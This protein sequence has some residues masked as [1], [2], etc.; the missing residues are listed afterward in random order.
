[1]TKGLL[2]LTGGLGG[3]LGCS[4]ELR[5]GNNRPWN[6][7][8][9]GNLGQGLLTATRLGD[10]LGTSEATGPRLPDAQTGKHVL[11]M[12]SLCSSREA[13]GMWADFHSSDRSGWI[14]RDSRPGAR[15]YQQ[16][17]S[18]SR[19]TQA[20]K[21]KLCF[22][23]S[24]LTCRTTHL[25]AFIGSGSAATGIQPAW[26]IPVHRS[27]GG[28]LCIVAAIV[29]SE[30]LPSISGL[31]RAQRYGEPPRLQLDSL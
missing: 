21:R 7:S 22:E 11:C 2:V 15:R 28:S 20:T 16:L 26:L 13:H 6:A 25:R 3:P 31:L 5:L 14:S 4:A 17:T 29:G 1:M 8:K 30:V 23:G 19:S 9:S 27:E 24:R 10:V 12:R 18:D